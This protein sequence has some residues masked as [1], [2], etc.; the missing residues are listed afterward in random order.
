MVLARRVHIA[1]GTTRKTC[2]VRT[3]QEIMRRQKD[4]P[5]A[6]LIQ[7]ITQKAGTKKYSGKGVSYAL[8]RTMVKNGLTAIGEDPTS[9]S[10]HSL[11]AGGATA[12]AHANIDTR[13]MQ[14]HGRWARQDSMNTYV[15][16][17]VSSKLAVSRATMCSKMF[18][19][20]HRHLRG[21]LNAARAR[22]GA[23]VRRRTRTRAWVRAGPRR[24][25]KIGQRIYKPRGN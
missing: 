14:R 2:P 1:A 6:R 24:R 10:T 23:H 20:R 17:D 22:S 19:C 3:V 11:R 16:D 7:S 21:G 15:D 25:G 18:V 9:Y 8:V 4:E 5:G 12:A 13:L